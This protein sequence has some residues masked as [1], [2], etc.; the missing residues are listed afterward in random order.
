MFGRTTRRALAAGLIALAAGIA[1]NVGSAQAAE[2]ADLCSTSVL[3]DGA[4]G[5][6]IYVAGK[7]V[8]VPKVEDISVCV[9]QDLVRVDTSPTQVHLFGCGTPCFDVFAPAYLGS[10][11][12]TAT[13][14]YTSDGSRVCTG[15][16]KPSS[17]TPTQPC[18]LS[19]GQPAQQSPSSCLV[20][21]DRDALLAGVTG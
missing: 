17:A 12:Y 6:T 14:C 5:V 15:A 7:P 9:R 4:G 10:G 18:L 2:A 16:T 1:G 13:V 21:I 3:P 8:R 19:V 20:V 11:S